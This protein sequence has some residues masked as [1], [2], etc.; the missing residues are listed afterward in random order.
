MQRRCIE[1]GCTELTERTRCAT[2]QRE[3]M[4]KRGYTSEYKQAHREARRML[5]P[6]L[7][8]G[9]YPCSRGCG[10]ILTTTSNWEADQRTYGWDITC[11]TCNRKAGALGHA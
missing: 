8:H 1:P 6:R 9:G 4:L 7:L 10:T 5:A 11:A 3:Y 2:H